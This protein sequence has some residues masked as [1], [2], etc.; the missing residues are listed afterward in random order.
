MFPSIYEGFGLPVLEAMAS[1]T[2]VICSNATS[3]PEVVGD[4]ALMHSPEDVET[5]TSYFQSMTEDAEKSRQ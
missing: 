3:L 1:G 4:E 5:L 2:P